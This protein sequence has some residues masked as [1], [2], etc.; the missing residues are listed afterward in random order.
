MATSRNLLFHIEALSADSTAEGGTKLGT[1]QCSSVSYDPILWHMISGNLRHM[2]H[3]QSLRVSCHLG[4]S[5][6]I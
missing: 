1:C 6:R 3:G 2:C 5:V 4:A